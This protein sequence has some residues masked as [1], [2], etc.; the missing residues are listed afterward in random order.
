MNLQDLVDRARSLSGIRLESIRS[1]E[2]I[3]TLLNETYEE[4]LGLHPWPFLRGDE[5]VALS[6]GSSDITL[7]S[8]FRYISAVLADD[9][10]LKQTTVDELDT[11]GPEEG[12][13]TLYAR[14]SDRVVRLWPKPK[15]SVVVKV[16]GQVS[17]DLLTR[18]SDE[19]EFAA[20]FHPILAYRAASRMLIEEGD[21]SG[22]SRSYQTDA[23]GYLKRME[24]YYLGTGDIGLIKIGSQR[25]G[26]KWRS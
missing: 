17:F 4:V 22:R 11:L 18:S 1:D 10:R 25:E 26:R 20:Q 2:Q 9:K 14:V 21:D 12:E 7:P 6:A 5:T 8:T 23:A 15:Q 13:P 3:Q 16:K 19:P 24:E